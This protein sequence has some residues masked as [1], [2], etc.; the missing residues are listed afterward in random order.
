[1]KKVI[2][3]LTAFAM[4]LGTVATSHADPVAGAWFEWDAAQDLDGNNVWPS[5]TTN[6]YNWQFDAGNQTPVDV[7]D[8]RF[9]KLTKA[10]AFPAASDGSSTTFDGLGGGEKVTFEFVLDADADDGLIFESGGTGDG[11]TFYLGGGTLNGYI[12]EGAAPTVGYVLT[13]ADKSRFMHIVFVADNSADVLQLYVDG[14]PK[15]SAAWTGGD[16]WS[17]PNEAALGDWGNG[18]VANDNT[19]PGDLTGRMALFRYYRN[20]A[21]TPEEVMQNFLWLSSEGIWSNLAVSNVTASSAWCSATLNTNVTE[22]VLVWDT[23][24][25]GTSNTTAWAGQ[26]SL[27]AQSAGP[28]TGNATGLVADTVYAYRFYGEYDA[29]NGWSQPETFA[30]ALTA[31]QTPVFTNAAGASH[32]TI[33]LRWQDNAAT[34]TDYVLQRA[35]STGGPYAVIATLPADTVTYTDSGLSSSTEYFYRLAVTNSSN[36]SVT[37][38]AACQTNATT[39]FRPPTP[40]IDGFGSA[41]VNGIQNSFTLAASFDAAGSDKLVVTVSMERDRGDPNTRIASVTYNGSNMTQAITFKN[42]G[43]GP[44]AIYYLDNPGPAGPIVANGYA[45][46]NGCHGS[47]LALSGTAE[48]VGPT[49]AAADVATSVTPSLNGSLVVAHNHVNGGTVPEA[50]PPLTPLLK[51]NGQYSEAAAGYQIV[52]VADTVTPTFSAGLTPVTVTAVF[53]PFVVVGQIVWSSIGVSNITVTSSWA[54][55]TINTNLDELVLVWDTSDKGTSN[56]ADWAYSLERGAAGAGEVTGGMTKLLA[57]TEYT[58]RFYGTNSYPTNGWSPAATFPTALTAAQKPA[59]TNTASSLNTVT[60]SWSDNAAT[61]T[62]YVLQRSDSGSDGPYAV[63]AT[64]GVD[65]TT[66][67]DVGLSPSTTY[68]YRLAASNAV[69]GSATALAACQT[70]ATTSAFDPDSRLLT[71][72]HVVSGS[73]I[74]TLVAIDVP[75]VGAGNVNGGPVWTADA[76]W[77]ATAHVMDN[78]LATVNDAIVADDGTSKWEPDGTPIG[79]ARA[80][81]TSGNGPA[82]SVEYTFNLDSAWV[83]IPDGSVINA[84]YSTWNRRNVDGVTYQYAEGAASD[85]TVR[86]TGGADPIADLVLRWTDSDSA[87]HDGNFER[88]FDGPIVVEGGDG[89]ELW[90]TDNVGNAAHIDAVVIDVSLPSS[91]LLLIVR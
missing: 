29:T 91:G 5:T 41:T 68:T 49:N 69:N 2:F 4:V 33:E 70:N 38:F 42:Y 24:D 1:M 90:A 28:V 36:G 30:T 47:W 17:G 79:E 89:F 18:S 80:Y 8:A 84:V 55:A 14:E 34:E 6:A 10:Y 64:L 74:G 71:A 73:A 61:E 78:G 52:E 51:S 19:D 87:T 82:P 32:S 67:M 23:S 15:D 48:G 11:I 77:G 66:H 31:A 81:R 35:D 9:D 7:A 83:D 63:V 62:A 40:V 86:Q 12:R 16:D 22:A 65:V 39:G 59:F 56:T 53:E 21:F 88:I 26:G 72:D 54:Y 45:K 50:Q 25:Q 3:T 76:A 43:E 85:S 37:D 60:L 44:A 27:G 75:Y 58:W 46:M 57:D 13:A 20:K